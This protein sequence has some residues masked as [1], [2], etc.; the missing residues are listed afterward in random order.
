MRLP[1]GRQAQPGGAAHLLPGKVLR[2]QRTPPSRDPHAPMPFCQ[3][4][5]IPRH[6]PAQGP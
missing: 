4:I 2:T 5:A 6:G 3:T 1:G